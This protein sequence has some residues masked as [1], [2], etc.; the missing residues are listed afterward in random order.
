MAGPRRED[1][2]VAR[3]DLER[4]ALRAAQLER[5]GAATTASTSCDVEWKWWNVNTPSTQLP[6]QPC[7]ANSARAAS[8]PSPRGLDAAVDEHGEARMVGDAVAGRGRPGLELHPDLLP[9]G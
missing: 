6:P 8:G 1:E 4:L 5:G 2:H 3:R 9:V 7:S